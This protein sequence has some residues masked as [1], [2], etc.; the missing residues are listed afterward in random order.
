MWLLDTDPEEPAESVVRDDLLRLVFTC[1]HPTLSR[2]AQ[3][4]L[5]LRTL[6]GL[7]TVEV[8]RALL[9]PEATMAKRLT[10]AKQKISQARIPYRIPADHELP[11]RLDGVLT[12]LY[13]I[14]KE[15]RWSRT[16]IAKWCGGS[17][18]CWPRST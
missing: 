6:G 16:S 5:S 8:A 18:P 7:S 1:C 2:E 17:P 13:L 4:A 3:V 12:T 11:A 10:R 9:V 14:F 15:R